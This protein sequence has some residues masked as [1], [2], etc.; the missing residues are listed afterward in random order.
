MLEISTILRSWVMSNFERAITI[1]IIIG[2]NPINIFIY[3]NK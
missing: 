3:I 1:L 2:V